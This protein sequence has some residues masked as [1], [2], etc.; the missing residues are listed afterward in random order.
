MS[1]VALAALIL[2]AAPPPRYQ[3]LAR[4]VLRELVEINTTHA[5]GSRRAAQAM[6]KRLVEAGFP[7]GDVH[8]LGPGPEKGNVVARLR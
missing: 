1:A 4:E 8:V 2:A 7:A 3:Q 5:F 6:G